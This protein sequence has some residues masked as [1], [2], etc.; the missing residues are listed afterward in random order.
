[1]FVDS[2]KFFGGEDVFAD[3]C[4]IGAGA[5]G[6]TIALE[7]ANK[8]YSVV[9]LESGGFRRDDATQALY[10]GAS[11]GMPYDVL[12]DCRSRYFGGSTNCWVGW[13][14]PLDSLDFENR[15]WRAGGGWP[16]TRDELTPYYERAQSRLLLG[17]L[18]Y[19]PPSWEKRLA[20]SKVS[21]LKFGAAEIDNF[22]DQL[23]PP[24]RLGEH[25]R[26]TLAAVSNVRVFLH[27]NA[28]ELESDPNATS[29]QKVRVA[30]LSG[31]TF[32]VVPKLVVLAAGGIENARLLLAS[33]R[34]EP[35]GLGNKNDLIGRY[36]M[37][38]PRVRS[39]RLRLSPDCDT[40]LYDHSLALVR[41]RLKIPHMPIAAFFAP[42]AQKQRE[43]KVGNSRTYLVASSFD[44]LWAAGASM[45]ALLRLLR[46][47][48]GKPLNAEVL[49][50]ASQVMRQAPQGAA[51][52]L[53]FVF[54]R[55]L[56]QREYFL[57]TVIEPTPQRDSRVTL[58]ADKDQLGMNKVQLEW[59]LAEAD[60]E[61][62][63]TSV[64]A[65]RSEMERQGFVVPTAPKQDAAAFWPSSVQWCWHHMGT[66]RIDPDPAKGVVD[67]D[68]RVHGL[69]NLFVAGSSVFPTAGSDTPTLTIVALA[70]RLSRRL[71][72][73]LALSTSTTHASRMSAVAVG[74][75][76]TL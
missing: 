16:F 31:N 60:R 24:A 32:S 53:D 64:E 25:C 58:S 74:A 29:V 48:G 13:C 57:E 39:L 51:A 50:A 8:Q 33:R 6:I 37:D 69:A 12:S 18:D 42:T 75:D 10:D 61:T 34:V 40:R 4:I 26:S 56:R 35:N 30:T 9:V 23:S 38:H 63:L 54:N 28:T 67:A 27:A 45:K 52:L 49:L 2:R 41:Q 65:V 68:C 5:A 55:R 59:R 46:G 7:F 17:P 47:C 22:I 70:L 44:R 20:G 76:P 3:I 14:R 66:T 1:M 15:P 71:E 19:H 73:V 21:F 62:Y 72:S 11:V 36:F 43:M